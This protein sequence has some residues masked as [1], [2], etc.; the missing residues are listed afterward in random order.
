MSRAT[1]YPVSWPTTGYES[2]STL[3]FAN[4]S[5]SYSATLLAVENSN[6][7][8]SSSFKPKG[9]SNMI[10]ILAPWMFKAPSVFRVHH[11]NLSSS[12]SISWGSPFFWKDCISTRKS[13]RTCPFLAIRG[14]NLMSHIP[15]SIAYL[16][17]LPD[18]SSLVNTAFNGWFVRTIIA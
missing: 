5:A 4:I 15:N 9:V 12:S 18:K 17:S 16:M 7:A 8:A 2:I 10:P 1:L 13:A 6:L 14:W 3:S 11:Y